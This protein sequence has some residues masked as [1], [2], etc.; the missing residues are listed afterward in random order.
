MPGLW[1]HVTRPVAF[2]L[3]VN[4]FGVKYVGRKH[5]DHLLSVLNQHYEMSEDWEG[6]KFAGIDL[7]WNYAA[8]HSERTC[9]LSMANY[10]ADLLFREGHTAPSQP[11][12]SPHKHREIIYGAKQ[13]YSQAD[14]NSAKLDDAG[15]TR[16][17]RIVGALLYYA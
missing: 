17:Q 1:K 10:I 7:E 12:R 3:V 8:R 4:D 11:Q 6:K 2:S 16:V 13:Q 14:D 9:R 5:A 15:I